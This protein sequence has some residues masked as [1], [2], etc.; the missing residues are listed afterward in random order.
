MAG[1]TVVGG[2]YMGRVFP[3]CCGAVMA[4]GTG[5]ID[6]TMIN[7]GCRRPGCGRVASLTV[8][9]GVNVGRVFAGG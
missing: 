7:S 5:A 3:G 2:V 4:T 9:G 1:F 6:F 8:I